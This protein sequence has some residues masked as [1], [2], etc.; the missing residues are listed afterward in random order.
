MFCKKCG[1][2]LDDDA[3]FCENCGTAVKQAEPPAPA[4][5]HTE[6]PIPTEDSAP[7]EAPMPM[8]RSVGTEQYIPQP[9]VYAQ[10]SPMPDSQPTYYPGDENRY[11]PT[12][13]TMPGYGSM[14]PQS[15][16]P[17]KKSKAWIFVLVG[18]LLAGIVAAVLL[19]MGP[20][21]DQIDL[22]ETDITIRIDETFSITY[23]ILPAE[24]KDAEVTWTSSN[25]AVATVNSLGKI[26]GNSEGTCTIT[27][28]AG[29]KTDTM[30]VTVVKLYEEEA[31]ILGDWD[32]VALSGSDDDDFTFVSA[33]TFSCCINDNFTG[34][35][36]LDTSVYE[37]TWSFNKISEDYYYYNA[38]MD[39]EQFSII[40]VV[41]EGTETLMIKVRDNYLV[42][43]K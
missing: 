17:K 25:E 12:G 18:V 42:L 40:Y 16:P 13:Y 41:I 37:F 24:A 21:V 33:G 6:A 29:R 7:T 35:V 22:S 38:T 9:P 20:S 26:V 32:G 14:P 1:I 27:I 10:E 23:T 30:S 8:E 15:Q 36:T 28:T 43:E 4:P 34:T 11:S 2:N 39:G 5:V 31:L 19:L 3:L